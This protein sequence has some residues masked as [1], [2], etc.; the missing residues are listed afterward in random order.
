[1]IHLYNYFMINRLYSDFK[2]YRVSKIKKFIEIRSYS[3]YPKDSPEFKIYSFFVLDWIQYQNPLWI[4]IP[5]I[6]KTKIKILE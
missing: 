2:F 6:K 5:F 1:M 4:K 3:Q